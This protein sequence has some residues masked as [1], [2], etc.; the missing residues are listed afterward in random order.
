MSLIPFRVRNRALRW[1]FD[2]QCAG[3]H[4]TRPVRCDSRSDVVVVSQ[5]YH[6]DM[7]MYLLAAK[8][9]AHWLRPRGF[10]IVDDGLT[11][12]DRAHLT[13]HLGELSFV[14]RTAVPNT[15]CPSGGCWERL[16]TLSDA[17]TSAYAI[18]L[19]S[20]TLT[21]AEP[22]EVLQ[23]VAAGRSF[24]LGTHSG[25]HLVPFAEA[26][27]YASSRESAHVQNAAERAL[28]RHPD[29]PRLRYVRG[30][31]GFTGFAK[32]ELP[33]ERIERFSSQ[34][35]GLL[36]EPAWRSWGTEQVTSNVMAANA[37]DAEVLPIDRYPFYLPS[38]DLSTSALVHFFGS[39]RFQQGAYARLGRQVINRLQG[40]A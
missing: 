9:L 13:H 10:V 15:R 21:L 32:G 19:D 22:T 2:H 38:E 11:T 37:P 33:R 28:G 40:L 4:R 26:A 36:G 31:A 35:S 1:W 8:S 30:C 3:V 27:Q 6:P 5:L 16:L 7:T 29:A 12:Q 20:D 24:T 34:M 25:T 17:N 39:F 14:A 23:C 18:Q